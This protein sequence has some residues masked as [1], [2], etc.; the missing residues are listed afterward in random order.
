MLTHHPSMRY[1]PF[2]KHALGNAGL[3]KSQFLYVLVESK[4]KGAEE[5]M[6]CKSYPRSMHFQTIKHSVR[7]LKL[8]LIQLR[9]NQ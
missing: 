2:I 4:T 8:P 7:R 1:N 6:L 3:P 9:V 5:M